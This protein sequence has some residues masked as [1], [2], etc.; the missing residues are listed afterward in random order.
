MTR[1]GW[2]DALELQNTLHHAVG[3]DEY[4]AYLRWF[5]AGNSRAYDHLDMMEAP[6]AVDVSDAQMH[7]LAGFISASA[8]SEE[9]VPMWV[10]GEVLE[11]VDYAS[12]TFKPEGVIPEDLVIPQA[13]CVFERA[14]Y[15]ID[16]L[17]NE[18]SFRAASWGP[19][20]DAEKRGLNVGLWHHKDDD[21]D[22]TADNPDTFKRRIAGTP[23]HLMQT[24]VLPW[25]DRQAMDQEPALYTV[26][27]QLQVLWRLA[28]Q[29]VTLTSDQRVSRPTWRD[30][31][32][33]REIKTVQ[34][35]TLRRARQAEYHG[36]PSG[37][38]HYSHR[39]PVRGHW[40][41]Q[42]YPSLQ[43][44]RQRWVDGYVKGPEDKPFVAKRQAVEFVR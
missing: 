1:H 28:K 36:D 30:K 11:L 8:A 43:A 35:M 2:D 3:S 9:Y 18:I 32:N 7:F 27:K 10:N 16:T 33:W 17:G 22:Y 20:E 39:F 41:N 25:S 14:L 42:W 31:R 40:R 26:F 6:R 19:Y 29:E 37:D 24:M 34:V 12:Q 13:F 4:A 23:L 5:S 38:S 21:D 44:H 15:S